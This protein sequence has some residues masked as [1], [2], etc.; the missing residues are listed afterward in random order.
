MTAREL[1]DLAGRQPLLMAAFFLAPPLAAALARWT[2]GPGLGGAPP[3]RYLYALLVYLACV[4]GIGAAVLTGYTLFFTRENLLDKDLLV[5]VVPI[6]SMVVT[7]VLIRKNVSFDDVPG[8]DRLSGLMTLI[9]ITFVILLAI[10]KTFIGIF[11]GASITTLFVL[12]AF[13][14]ALLKWGAYAV[15]RGSEEPRRRPPGFPGT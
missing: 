15:F 14:F 8:F 10:R 6:V 4:P 13:L 7:L 12:G 3:W 11:F 9:G 2:H 1:I 5:Y